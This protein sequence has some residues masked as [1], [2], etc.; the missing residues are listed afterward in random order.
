MTTTILCIV[1]VLWPLLAFAG[2]LG[3]SPLAA[4]V[5]VVALPAAIEKFRLRP[6]MAVFVAFLV[7][8]TMSALWSPLKA[9]IADI[10]F[11]KLRFNIKS[12]VLRTG[13]VFLAFGL[14]HQAGVDDEG[15]DGAANP[16]HTI[17]TQ[18]A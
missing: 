9:S 16:L 10:D 8:A 4:V 2:G 15:R 1:F 18:A 14:K 3:F 7:F 11:G 5:A 17:T 13:L 6:Y 12:D